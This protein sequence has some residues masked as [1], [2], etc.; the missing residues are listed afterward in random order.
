MTHGP[1]PSRSDQAQQ[2]NAA[3]GSGEIPTDGAGAARWPLE[4]TL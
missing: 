3:A 4:T 2:G 1:E